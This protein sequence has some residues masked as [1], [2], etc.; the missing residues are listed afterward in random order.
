MC[1]EME[2]LPVCRAD[3]LSRQLGHVV[4]ADPTTG[5]LCNEAVCVVQSL[6]ALMLMSRAAGTPHFFGSGRGIPEVFTEEV[7]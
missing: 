4:S 1:M 6:C 5:A 3:V 7:L 2:R